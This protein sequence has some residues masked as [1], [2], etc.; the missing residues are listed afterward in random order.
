M[1]LDGPHK[2]CIGMGKILMLAANFISL[3]SP[4]EQVIS[5]SVNNNQ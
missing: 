4:M 2:Y 3:F 1:Q 5:K